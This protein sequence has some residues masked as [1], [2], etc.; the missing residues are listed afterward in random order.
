[1]IVMI[2]TCGIWWMKIRDAIEQGKVQDMSDPS[3][4]IRAEK[5][6]RGPDLTLSTHLTTAR[7]GAGT[8]AYKLRE[9]IP[10]TPV[11]F[12]VPILGD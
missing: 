2:R 3:G 8:T 1:M 6:A 5:M 11:Q 9:L 7:V 12:L 4:H 10:R